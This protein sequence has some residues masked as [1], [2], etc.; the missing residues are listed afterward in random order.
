MSDGGRICLPRSGVNGKGGQYLEPCPP[1]LLRDV[2]A[3][4]AL[5]M[6]NRSYGRD[7]K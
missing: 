4:Q 6:L 2:R 5:D 7:T 1:F 3:I